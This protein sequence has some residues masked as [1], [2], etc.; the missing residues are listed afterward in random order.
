MNIAWGRLMLLA[1]GVTSFL[2]FSGWSWRS[3]ATVTETRP[4]PQTT[5]E[6][7]NLPAQINRRR[8]VTAAINAIDRQLAQLEGDEKTTNKIFG[9][10]DSDYS[11]YFSD[12]VE[13]DVSATHDRNSQQVQEPGN[14]TIDC[15]PSVVG[16]LSDCLRRGLSQNF[17]SRRDF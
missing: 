11:K 10:T 7:K 13:H 1:V 14:F 5:C 3:S 17:L 16:Q 15:T 4:E 12:P 9:Y 8:E 6:C 2:F